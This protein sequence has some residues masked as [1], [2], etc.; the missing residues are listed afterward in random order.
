MWN[1]KKHVTSFNVLSTNLA[2]TL[3]SYNRHNETNSR[4][5]NVEQIW[6]VRDII[7]SK[8]QDCGVSLVLYF[9]YFL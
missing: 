3:L 4:E 2:K 6:Q 1:M 8:Q 9:K 5:V 7:N